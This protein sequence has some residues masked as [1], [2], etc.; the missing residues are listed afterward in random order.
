MKSEARGEEGRC[1]EHQTKREPATRRRTLTA[2]CS[3]SL[4]MR[5][6]CVYTHQQCAAVTPASFV[7]GEIV[8]GSSFK[9]CVVV[10]V[11]SA[12]TLPNQQPNQP[13]S[14]HR[15]TE[16]PTAASTCT[17]H[18]AHC[19]L[20]SAHCTV[21][22]ATSLKLMLPTSLTPSLCTSTVEALPL[23]AG[24]ICCTI[25]CHLHHVHLRSLQAER[26]RRKAEAEATA[27]RS[28]QRHRHHDTAHKANSGYR[29]SLSLLGFQQHTT[30]KLSS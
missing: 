16:A 2:A 5:L 4:A 10:S 8:V 28:R 22:D 3:G 21:Q 29:F 6:Q 30:A 20:H 19:T 1:E 14:Q 7:L 9:R 15:A 26:C 11:A 13:M 18:T 23:S 27:E 12:Q 25:L 17:L 24:P